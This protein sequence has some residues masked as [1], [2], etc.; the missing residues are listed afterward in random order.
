MA[1]STTTQSL[2]TALELHRAGNL[3]DAETLYREI[4]QN[5]PA[6]AE[7]LHYLGLI[8]HQVGQ[9]QP[10]ADLIEQS[11]SLLPDNAAFHSNLGLAYQALGRHTQAIASFREALR[12]QPDYLD[13]YNNLANALSEEGTLDEAVAN[14]RRALA[15]NP[16][17][18]APHYNLAAALAK[19]GKSDEAAASYRQALQLKPDYFKAH[20]NL[21]IV[22]LDSQKPDE[23]LLHFR[24]CLKLD[25][26][27]S[28]AHNNL[29]NALRKLQRPDEA[30]ASY[31][32]ALLHQPDCA[33]AFFNLGN[34]YADQKQL[35]EAVA[36]FQQ[37]LRLKPGMSDTMAD[38]QES[39]ANVLGEQGKSSEAMA[40]F[41]QAIRLRPTAWRRIALAM[42]LPVV[43]QSTHDL[44]TWRTRLSTEIRK[45]RDQQ[46]IHDLVDKPAPILF[47]L[48]YQGLND[49]DIQR[50]AGL[51]FR[52]PPGIPSEG[53]SSSIA[54]RSPD[55][56]SGKIRVGFVSAFFK[57]H[58][59]GNWMRGLIAQL[60]RDDFDVT[61]LSI[62]SHD[63]DIAEFIKTHADHFLEVPV[64]LPTA[65][66]L[67]ADQSLDVL[68]YADIGMEAI[69]SS[70]AFSRLAPVQCV[71]LG[72]PVTTGIDTIDYFISAESM[73]TPEAQ[74]HYTEKLIQLKVPPFYFYRPQLAAKLQKR[75]YF[76]LRDEDHVYLC[77]QSPFKFH[78]D[79][80]QVLGGILR[81]DP[82]GVL[83]LTHWIPW[84]QHLRQRFAAT[85]PDVEQRIR[86]LP[87]LHY[88][89]YLNLLAVA[90]VQ[91]DTL[92]F[93]G[94]STSYEALA[95]GTPVVTLPL[96]FLRSRLTYSFY[97]QMNVMDCVAQS[98]QEYIDIALRLGT[99]GEYCH[100]V[101]KK[102]LA[103]QGVIHGNAAGIREL[104]HFFR[105][106]VKAA[107]EGAVLDQP[108]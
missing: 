36:C 3:S 71:T 37:A 53:K 25:S 67:I 77:L 46:V 62:G 108:P 90:N 11:I 34:V 92:H 26:R 2:A 18:A 57:A 59:I 32:L 19:Q 96:R 61:V 9:H 49:R 51:L 81:G 94:G 48:A 41:E 23:A 84:E 68:F 39:L 58:T 33:E 16:N 24:E 10:A 66:R 12:L 100:T 72:H 55:L 14:Y 104:E 4:L 102:I 52:A 64:N 8:A 80:D 69:S 106:A 40:S 87:R 103:A 35:E 79:F 99:D 88:Q 5:D 95:I 27:S 47:Y 63:D 21:G 98:A 28:A 70:L 29:G 1:M 101:R 50:D 76:D 89:D 7:A 22:L 30:V 65:R 105:Q 54:H 75:G 74:Q 31:R 60:A 97:K 56:S 73:E 17:V 78:P 42:H 83:L 107:S 38:A 15:L 82:R 85:L 91:L 93:G 20:L 45:L 44:D 13:A 6:H 86:F 43:Y